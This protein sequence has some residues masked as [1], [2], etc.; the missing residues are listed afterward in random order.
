M[1]DYTVNDFN[2]HTHKGCDAFDRPEDADLFRIS[3]HTPIKGVTLSP[4]LPINNSSYFNP[5]THKG[6]DDNINCFR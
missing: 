1:T 2:P 6:C 5:H 3:I 4:G